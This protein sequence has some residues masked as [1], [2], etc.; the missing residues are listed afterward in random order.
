VQ[1]VAVVGVPDRER[2]TIVKAFV[3]PSPA[4]SAGGALRP[5]LTEE[6]RALVRRTVAVYKCPREFAFVDALPRTSTG[7]VRRSVLRQEAA[8]AAEGA[9]R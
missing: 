5:Y 4:A 1:E 7:K 3:V 6:L 2:G 8:R 9:V